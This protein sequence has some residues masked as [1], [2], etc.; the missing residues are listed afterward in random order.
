MFSKT[1]IETRILKMALAME[2][3]EMDPAILEILTSFMTVPFKG[4][5]LTPTGIRQSW[6]IANSANNLDYCLSACL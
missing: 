1:N 2:P 4:I 3:S 5:I 6:A